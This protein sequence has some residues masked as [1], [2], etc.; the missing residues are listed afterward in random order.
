LIGLALALAAGAIF[1]ALGIIEN[2]RFLGRHDWR[3]VVAGHLRD[4]VADLA[5]PEPKNGHEGEKQAGY[6][7]KVICRRHK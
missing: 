5:G 2:F 6:G 3:L 1:K 7:E 4:F